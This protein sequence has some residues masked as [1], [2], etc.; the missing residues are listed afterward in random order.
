MEVCRLSHTRAFGYIASEAT[1]I[2]THL[3]QRSLCWLQGRRGP[4]R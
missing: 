1:T 2:F 3:P 4:Q